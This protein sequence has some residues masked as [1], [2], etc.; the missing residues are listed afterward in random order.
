MNFEQHEGDSPIVKEKQGPK[1]HVHAVTNP[2]G[3]VT[4]KSTQP[5]AISFTDIP[6]ASPR[7]CFHHPAHTRSVG[8]SVGRGRG[9]GR[10]WLSG[11][12]V[13]ASLW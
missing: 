11:G 1:A 6:H 8:R 3:F 12:G 13:G 9:F 4:A 7:I 10:W 2:S 5:S